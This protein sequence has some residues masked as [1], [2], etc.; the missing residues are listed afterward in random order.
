[1]CGIC[2]IIFTGNIN[3]N[4]QVTINQILKYNSSFNDDLLVEKNSIKDETEIKDDKNFS[5]KKGIVTFLN[6]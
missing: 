4:D 5:N 6:D 2:L 3:E 1:M